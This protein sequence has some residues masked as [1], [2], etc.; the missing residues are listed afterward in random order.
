VAA[1]SHKQFTALGVEDFQQK[2]IK[3]GCFIDV[4]ASFDPKPFEAAG[5]KVWRL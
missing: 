5:I 2:L 1:V 4:K 3:G